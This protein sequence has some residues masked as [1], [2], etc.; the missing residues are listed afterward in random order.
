MA[1]PLLEAQAISKHFQGTSVL[2]SVHMQVMPKEIVTLIGPNGAGK[3]TLL[4]CLLGLEAPDTGTIVQHAALRIGYMPQ[5]FQ[6]PATMPL[7]VMGFLELYAPATGVPDALLASLEITA[8]RARQLLALS[9]GELRRVLLARALLNRPNLLVLDEPTQGIDVNGQN[10]FYQRIARMPEE[11][12]CAVLM[13]SHDLH[14]VMASTHR[15]ICLNRHICC[16]GAPKAV[17]NA[18]A[19]RQLFGDALASQLA[20]Y[21]HHHTHA[22]D[23]H[24]DVVP[25]EDADPHVGCTHG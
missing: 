18:P 12:H 6:P 1:S 20:L 24:G 17:G 13:V 7:T 15:V 4:R 16:E 11:H 23:L 8:L 19:F 2:E 14:V 5:Q 10:E 25:L 9:G 3:T 21:Q 22:H